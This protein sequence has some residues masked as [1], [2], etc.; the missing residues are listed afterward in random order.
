MASKTALHVI[1]VPPT[2]ITTSAA[3]AVSAA[4]PQANGLDIYQVVN[5]GGKV[6]WN[7]SSS[8]IATTNP[9]K[10]TLTAA[11][12][13]FQGASFIAAFTDPTH[14]QLDFLQIV[15]GSKIVYRVDYLGNGYT[16]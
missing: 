11:A 4:H 9:A 15:Q 16:S 5:S 2:A 6:V 12:A 14:A 13:R 8:G 10:P 1:S 3:M 7:L